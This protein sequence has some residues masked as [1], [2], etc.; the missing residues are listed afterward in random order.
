MEEISGQDY[1]PLAPD[2]TATGGISF[3]D[4][5][6]FSGGLQFR[7][8]DNRPAN[9][10]NSIIAEG[11][12]VSDFNLNYTIKNITIGVSIENIFDTDWNE[13]QFATTSQL[14]NETSP[15]EE[16]HF[17]PGTP[18]NAKATITYKF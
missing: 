9:E 5:H 1:I 6:N 11:Y 16:I 7:Y 15:V 3:N 12:F 13:T 10:D 14:S 8:L 4:V 18:F 2:F 17:T